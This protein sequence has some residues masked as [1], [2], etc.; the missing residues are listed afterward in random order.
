MT[1][2]LVYWILYDRLVN[3]VIID[4]IVQGTWTDCYALHLG[5]KMQMLSNITGKGIE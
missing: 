2:K 1:L 3:T 4:I 5:I